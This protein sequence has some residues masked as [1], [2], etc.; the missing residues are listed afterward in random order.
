MGNRAGDH[1]EVTCCGPSDGRYLGDWDE[2][3][4]KREVYQN[5]VCRVDVRKSRLHVQDIGEVVLFGRIN[6]APHDCYAI[7]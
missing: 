5:K 3:R 6:Q 2:V 4:K 7:S 1:V